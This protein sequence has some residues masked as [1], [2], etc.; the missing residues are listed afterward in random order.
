[1]TPTLLRPNSYFARSKLPLCPEQTPSLLRA[2]FLWPKT[3]QMM[4]IVAGV[5]QDASD[6]KSLNGRRFPQLI[7]II[8]GDAAYEADVEVGTLVLYDIAAEEVAEIVND[9]LAD[10]WMVKMRLYKGD[11]EA[12]NR[13][14]IG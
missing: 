6:G 7:L 12:R 11:N 13:L 3:L 9:N 4:P 5:F 8:P 2:K 14:A 1:M 10:S